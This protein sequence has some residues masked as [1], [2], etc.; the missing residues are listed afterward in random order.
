MKAGV[1]AACFRAVAHKNPGEIS[2][3]LSAQQLFVER[4]T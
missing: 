2:S 1:G 4:T 3:S